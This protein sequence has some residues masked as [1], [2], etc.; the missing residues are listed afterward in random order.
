M[1][2]ISCDA[3][4]ESALVNKDLLFVCFFI[5]PFISKLL[6]KKFANRDSNPGQLLGRQL[7]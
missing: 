6:K 3:S 2:F 1:G 7:S 4:P 5:M